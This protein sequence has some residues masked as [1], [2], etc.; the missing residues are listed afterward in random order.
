LQPVLQCLKDSSLKLSVRK[1]PHR[2]S[3]ARA[4]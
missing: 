3:R 4:S 1:D 2:R